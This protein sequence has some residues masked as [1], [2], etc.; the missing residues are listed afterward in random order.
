MAQ[1][2]EIDI[3]SFG[4]DRAHTFQRP[5]PEARVVDHVEPA[6]HGDRSGM[7]VADVHH[8]DE[9]PVAVDLEATGRSSPQAKNKGGN[10]ETSGHGAIPFNRSGRLNARRFTFRPESVRVVAPD[11]DHAALA[12]QPLDQTRDHVVTASSSVDG[13]QTILRPLPC[14]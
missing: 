5:L 10:P 7:T 11:V 8:P 2:Q 13:K 1:D 6:R 12:Q 14:P 3:L 4:D 9:R